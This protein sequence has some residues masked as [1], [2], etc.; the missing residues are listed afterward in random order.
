MRGTL[1]ILEGPDGGGTTR[2]SD[3]LADRLRKSGIDVL[4]T[5]EPTDSVIGQQ[6]R[7]ILHG[8]TMPSAEA[9][10]LLFCADR[11]EHVKNVIEPALASGKVVICDR[12]ILSTLLY[13]SVLGVDKK[14]LEQVNNV[15][16]QPDLT[17]ITLP[18]FEV[19]CERIDR[20]G[21]RDQFEG[22]TFQRQVYDAYKAVEDPNV[23]FVDTSGEKEEVADMIENIVRVHI[24]LPSQKLA[25]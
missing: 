23:V 3:F 17:I 2:H 8:Q 22:N 24:A 13:G 16:P 20:R 10:Q 11:A 15:F 1:I 4:L 21:V 7:S 5:A 19:C 9:V 6:I 18:P 25:N 14:W 12:Y